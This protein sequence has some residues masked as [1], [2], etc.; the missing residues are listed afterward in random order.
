[1]ADSEAPGAESGELAF[2][3][4]AEEEEEEE[5]EAEEEDD[6]DEEAFGDGFVMSDLPAHSC[7]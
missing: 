1:M 7:K 5:E 4:E 2:E 3:E 6:E